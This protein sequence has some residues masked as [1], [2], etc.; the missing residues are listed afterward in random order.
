MK[1]DWDQSKEASNVE[2]HGVSFAEAAACFADPNGF[3]AHD[4]DH[5]LDEL[6]WFW[7]GLSPQKRILTVRYTQRGQTIRIIGAGA[8]RHGKLLYEKI[9]QSK[10]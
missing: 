7:F 1:F 2:K 10:P 5:S 8:W 4:S 6:R 9:N 3:V